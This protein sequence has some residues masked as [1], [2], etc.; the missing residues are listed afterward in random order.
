MIST[1]HI[2]EDGD[3]LWKLPNGLIH[4]EDGPAITFADG[5]TYW[6]LDGQGYSFKDYSSILKSDYGK[7]DEDIMLIRMKYDTTN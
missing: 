5:E 7:T 1:K 4:R 2:D 6:W 3:E